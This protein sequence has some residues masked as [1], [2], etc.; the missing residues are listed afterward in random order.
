MILSMNKKEKVLLIGMAIGCLFT[1]LIFY[2]FIFSPQQE[3]LNLKQEELQTQQKLLAAIET[4]TSEIANHSYRD[5]TSMQE[6]IPV[7]PLTEQLLLQFEKAEVLS[8]SSIQS[9]SFAKEDFI[10][11]NEE[12]ALEN[13]EETPK[14]QVIENDTS[15]VKRLQITM[16]VES[17]N[18]FSMEKFI[19]TLENLERIVEVNQ[20][21]FE[22]RKEMSP[23]ITG[24]VPQAITYQLVASAFYLPELT[25]L[26]DSIPSI[27][28]PPPSLKKNPFIQYTD[29]AATETDQTKDDALHEN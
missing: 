10:F 26:Q 1:L 4:K 20:L 7:D 8:Q 3:S 17:D 12:T 14:E 29:P 11:S 22:G 5:T 23:A 24:E 18:Y 25:D 15:S 27:D 9:M 2:F 6:Q 28:S 16:T 21:V 19:S 13:Q